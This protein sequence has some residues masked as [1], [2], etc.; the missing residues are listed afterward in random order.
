MGWPDLFKLF[1]GH[2]HPPVAAPD[3]LSLEVL[4]NSAVLKRLISALHPYRNA[5]MFGSLQH[6]P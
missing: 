6:P 5:G 2:G 3:G 1:R 4:P